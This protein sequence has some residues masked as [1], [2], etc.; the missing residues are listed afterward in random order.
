MATLVKTALRV[1]CRI[2]KS[3]VDKH[4]QVKMKPVT[5]Q[6]LLC[7]IWS[8]LFAV[9]AVFQLND[10]DPLLW[11]SAYFVCSGLWFAEI[12]GYNTFWTAQLPLLIL[13]FWMG[14]LIEAPID[15]LTFGTL[16]DLIGEMSAEKPYTEE[17]REFFG[18]AI[19][20]ASLLVLNLRI[21]SR[22]D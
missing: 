22:V 18:I 21:Y 20:V 13:T 9:F 12:K 2:E 17:S 1:N 19:C 11:F 10:S 15:L 4:N 5:K 14:T 7:C 16:A 8:G 3:I 6:K